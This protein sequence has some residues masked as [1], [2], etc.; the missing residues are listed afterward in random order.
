MKELRPTPG[1]REQALQ[2][3]EAENGPR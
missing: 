1:F 3:S 2:P